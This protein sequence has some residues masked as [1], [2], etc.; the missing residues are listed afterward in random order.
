MIVWVLVIIIIFL[1][2]PLLLLEDE[3]WSV[4]SNRNNIDDD[5][6]MFDFTT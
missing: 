3:S 1:Y 2:K 4:A 6:K 5:T